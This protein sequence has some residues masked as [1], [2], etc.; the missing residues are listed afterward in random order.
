MVYGMAMGTMVYWIATETIPTAIRMPTMRTKRIQVGTPMKCGLLI[1]TDLPRPS[2]VR[3][4][5]YLLSV[6]NLRLLQA[7]ERPSREQVR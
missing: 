6:M 3:S 2:L 7:L 5:P 1:F 4:R